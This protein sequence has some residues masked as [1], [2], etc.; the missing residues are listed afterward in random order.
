METIRAGPD[1]DTQTVEMAFTTPGM[2]VGTVSYMSPEQTRGEPLD[3]R[4]D[5]FSLGCVLY[6]AA[7]GLLP[8]RGPSA[9]AIM[10]EIA[11][12][13]PPAPSSLRP[14]LPPEF[15]VVIER[16]LAKDKDRRC[17]S[18]LELA[19]ALQAVHGEIRPPTAPT[20]AGR[21]PEAL[22]GREPEICRLQ[23]GLGTAMRGGGKIVFLT[24]GP[25]IGKSALA[26]AF[27]F[28]ARRDYPEM[29][30]GRGVCIEQYGAGEAYLP[31]LDALSGLL[32]GS[33][34]E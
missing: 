23:E 34:R 25:G 16:T 6:E 30:V 8:F 31:F 7:P 28:Q 17:A 9:L 32:S 33:G 26:E 13:N 24:G 14:D 11:T 4:S 12:V 20:V 22:V 19:E 3:G 2:L 5:I 10:H 27:L 18:A 15:D 21:R 29:L 1:V